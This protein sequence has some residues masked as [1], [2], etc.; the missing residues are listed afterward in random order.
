VIPSAS[1]LEQILLNPLVSVPERRSVILRAAGLQQVRRGDRGLLRFPAQAQG[2]LGKRGLF[3]GLQVD[4]LEAV[5]LAGNGGQNVHNLI[6]SFN[7]FPK[8]VAG[9]SPPELAQGGAGDNQPIP[10]NHP[11][12]PGMKLVR[13]RTIVGIDQ[14]NFWKTVADQG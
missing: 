11:K 6:R 2:G 5:H 1:T 8:R 13:A 14:N 3:G 4:L 9:V 7:N 12:Q 10:T